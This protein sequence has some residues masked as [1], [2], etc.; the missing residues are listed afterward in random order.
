[1]DILHFTIY[2]LQIFKHRGQPTHSKISR[3]VRRM[4]LGI[5][6]VGSSFS[7]ALL[8]REL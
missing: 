7:V 2:N 6:I 8:T 4:I 3:P 5:A 1:M